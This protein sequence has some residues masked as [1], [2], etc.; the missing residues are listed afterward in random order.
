MKIDFVC[1]ANSNLRTE[2]RDY[3][4]NKQKEMNSNSLVNVLKKDN[5]TNGALTGGPNLICDRIKAR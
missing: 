1:L 2:T 5:E 4:S 3:T